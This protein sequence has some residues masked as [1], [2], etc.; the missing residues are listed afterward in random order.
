MQWTMTKDAL[1][2]KPSVKSY[3]HVE[4]IIRMPNGDT[5]IRPWNCE[6][7][8]W[9]DEFGDDFEF[10]A[11]DPVAWIALSDLPPIPQQAKI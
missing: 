5:L 3:E 7:L 10:H 9:D 6:H 1:P 11:T 4:C 8:V 2:K